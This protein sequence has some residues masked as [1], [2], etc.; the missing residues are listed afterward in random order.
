MYRKKCY[1]PIN[2]RWMGDGGT[3]LVMPGVQPSTAQYSAVQHRTVVLYNVR[4]LCSVRCGDSGRAER[5]RLS[6]VSFREIGTS[7][8]INQ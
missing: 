8:S 2:F 1:K 7:N 3:A 4:L 5:Y 6:E